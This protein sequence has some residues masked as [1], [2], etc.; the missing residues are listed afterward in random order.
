MSLK[1]VWALSEV[2]LFVIFGLFYTKH[3]KMGIVANLFNCI[4]ICSFCFGFLLLFRW[5]NIFYDMIHLIHGKKFIQLKLTYS[6]LLMF[7]PL[8]FF[9]IILNFIFFFS[10]F[11]PQTFLTIIRVDWPSQL[12]HIGATLTRFIFKPGLSKKSV[13]EVF[14]INA[15]FFQFFRLFLPVC[16]VVFGL[17][18]LIG[19]GQ[20]PHNLILNLG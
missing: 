5:A 4:Y 9:F 10:Q 15:F 20:L 12:N 16:L 8:V 6:F 13:Q 7:N 19:S 3:V 17:T 14:S 1:L 2:H 11:H 18:K